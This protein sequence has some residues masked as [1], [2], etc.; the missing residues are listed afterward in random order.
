[1]KQVK[2]KNKSNWQTKHRT[3][4]SHLPPLAYCYCGSEND[5][6][7]EASITGT[8]LFSCESLHHAVVAYQ[9][10]FTKLLFKTSALARLTDSTSTYIAT[11]TDLTTAIMR[12]ICL[13]E[14]HISNPRLLILLLSGLVEIPATCR[15]SGPHYQVSAEIHIDSHTTAT[16]S[17][18]FEEFL[19]NNNFPRWTICWYLAKYDKS[20]VGW[21]AL[22]LHSACVFACFNDSLPL[23]QTK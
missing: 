20:D 14:R 18:C 3:I 7:R 16:G 17:V 6:V 4:V 2:S 21:H 13:K 19:A 9:A 22:C 23:P 10:Q 15:T 5:S 8:I 1:M 12:C 11:K